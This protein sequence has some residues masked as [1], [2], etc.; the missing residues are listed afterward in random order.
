MVR[1][2]AT[3][4]QPDTQPDP[5][6]PRKRYGTSSFDHHDAELDEI[7]DAEIVEPAGEPADDTP[8][9]IAEMV[10]AGAIDR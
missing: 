3:R 9:R 4:G 7:L 8:L 10:K 6:P 5:T 1:H 2:L